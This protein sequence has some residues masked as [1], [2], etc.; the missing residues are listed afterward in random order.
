MLERVQKQVSPTTRKIN[1]KQLC[2]P[3]SFENIAV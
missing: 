1:F 3:V 2:V